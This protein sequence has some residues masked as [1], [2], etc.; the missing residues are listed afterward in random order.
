MITFNLDTSDVTINSL[1]ADKALNS[2]FTFISIQVDSKPLFREVIGKHYNKIF[3]KGHFLQDFVFVFLDDC[4]ID[5]P[6]LLEGES[7]TYECAFPGDKI[8]LEP[9][10]S[11]IKLIYSSEANESMNELCTDLKG[12]IKEVII[13][14]EKSLDFVLTLNPAIKNTTFEQLFESNLKKAKDAY[15]KTYGEEPKNPM[16]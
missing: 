5:I 4:L 14:S 1:K 6:R 8:I 12:F 9:H 7:S 13:F 11:L 16:I 15:L 10:N 3:I 2:I